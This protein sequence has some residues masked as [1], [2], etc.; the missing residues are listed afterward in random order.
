MKRLLTS[1]TVIALAQC[2]ALGQGESVA[3]LFNSTL[4]ESKAIAVHYA[5]LR[6][7]PAGHL[8]GLPLSDGHTISRR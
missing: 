6:G 4:P 7:V 8:I 2:A 5:K 3:V 1:I